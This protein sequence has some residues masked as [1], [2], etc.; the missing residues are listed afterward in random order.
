MG[1]QLVRIYLN[2]YRLVCFLFLDRNIRTV[3][4]LGM[5][6][7]GQNFHQKVYSGPDFLVKIRRR[8]VPQRLRWSPD[9]G[10]PGFQLKREA[11]PR[12]SHFRVPTCNIRDARTGPR[13]SQIPRKCPAAP[14]TLVTPQQLWLYTH[15]EAGLPCGWGQL[16]WHGG[17][18]EH[19]S[20]PPP[21]SGCIILPCQPPHH[22]GS[23]THIAH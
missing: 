6:K 18:M 5:C 16:Q 22:E 8:Q 19:P 13:V 3:I 1:V 10:S 20:P 15:G 12:I 2:K 4:F 21:P 7:F 9:C 17:S 11:R 14:G 23:Q